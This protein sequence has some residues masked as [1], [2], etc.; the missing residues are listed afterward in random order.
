MFLMIETVNF[1]PQYMQVVVSTPLRG[2]AR[3]YITSWSQRQ[4][5][6]LNASP[7][8]EHLYC[9]I[10]E[11]ELELDIFNDVVESMYQS[12]IRGD[13]IVLFLKENGN[14]RGNAEREGSIYTPVCDSRVQGGILRSSM[15]RGCKGLPLNQLG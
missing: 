14:W 5:S 13:E 6:V 10:E 8:T 11:V 7:Q 15:F 3:Q 12:E 1:W 4:R 2:A 9:W